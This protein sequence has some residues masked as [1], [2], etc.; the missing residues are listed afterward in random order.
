MRRVETTGNTDHHPLAGRAEAPRQR[1]HLDV[2]RLV[3]IQI[4]VRPQLVAR[5]ES[6][7]E[8]VHRAGYEIVPLAGIP[9]A[10]RA[11]EFTES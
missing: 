6:A 8:A 2:E 7:L 11:A 5:W 3:A 1:D 4:Q 9:E 10:R